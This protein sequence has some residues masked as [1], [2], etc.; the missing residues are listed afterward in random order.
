MFNPHLVTQPRAGSA[1]SSCSLR[2]SGSPKLPQQPLAMFSKPFCEEIPPNVQPSLAHPE[3]F[4]L[5]TLKLQRALRPDWTG[6]A[7]AGAVPIAAG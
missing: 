7:A 2:T 5:N 6:V 3:P 4:L 1:T